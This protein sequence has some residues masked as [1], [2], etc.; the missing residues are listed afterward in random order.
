MASIANGLTSYGIVQ[1]PGGSRWR[2][3][4]AAPATRRAYDQANLLCLRAD[5][6][7]NEEVASQFVPVFKR[8]HWWKVLTN[9]T[10]AYWTQETLERLL[11][12]DDIPS[13]RSLEVASGTYLCARTNRMREA[14]SRSA[15]IPFS[16][17]IAPPSPSAS[18]AYAPYPYHRRPSDERPSPAPLSPSS[19]VSSYAGNGMMTT[20]SPRI[21]ATQVQV[22]GLSLAPLEVLEECRRRR[23]DPTDE[24]MVRSLN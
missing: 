6:R 1:V 5:T 20:S 8:Q 3:C 23:R 13:L 21:Y 14:V 15:R 18:P 12:V 10:D 24:G 19:S 11:T 7:R 4:Y 22:Q 2:I 16:E 9:F 17:G